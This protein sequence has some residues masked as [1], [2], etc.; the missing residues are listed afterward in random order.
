MC[1]TGSGSPGPTGEEGDVREMTD[2]TWRGKVGG[3]S[4]DEKGAFLAR[5]KP[6]RIACVKVRARAQSYG[7]RAPSRNA[8]KMA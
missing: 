8:P 4:D 1:R 6:M 5:G 3:M 2:S 7:I